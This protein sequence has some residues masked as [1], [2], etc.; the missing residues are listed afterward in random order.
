MVC[1]GTEFEGWPAKGSTA[2]RATRVRDGMRRG[3]WAASTRTRGASWAFSNHV[4]VQVGLRFLRFFLKKGNEPSGIVKRPRELPEPTTRK[5]WSQSL[6]NLHQIPANG[7]WG[8]TWTDP[9]ATQ[10]APWLDPAREAV[11]LPKPSSLWKRCMRDMLTKPL[12]WAHA[13]VRV[14]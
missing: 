6:A 7:N 13:P 14:S 1:Y 11:A 5:F 9:I 8:F 4:Q 2:L 12:N 3:T 10:R